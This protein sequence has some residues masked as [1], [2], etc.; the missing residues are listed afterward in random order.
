[1]T[2]ASVLA[3]LRARGVKV[4][5][6]DGDR[7]AVSPGSALDDRLRDAVRREKPALVAL[8]RD[9]P[10]PS[11]PAH[12]D[13]P[14][15]YQTL[16]ETCGTAEDLTAFE[17]Y[18]TLN[19]DAIIDEIAALERRCEDLARD[20]ADEGVYRAAVTALVERIRQMALRD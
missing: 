14:G 13:Y 8:L 12:A 3:A 19:G 4:T 15:I 16:T 20:G 1:M 9:K 18:A 10:L 7:L 6:L 2:P 11:A 5:V 17:W